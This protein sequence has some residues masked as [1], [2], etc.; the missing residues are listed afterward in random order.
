MDD[1]VGRS[2]FE[3]PDFEITYK[4]QILKWFLEVGFPQP[5][6]NTQNLKNQILG[7][8]LD[9]NGIHF[10]VIDEIGHIKKQSSL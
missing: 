10:F 2:E 9:K 5:S 6:E 1:K 7:R 8:Y 4:D 3:Q